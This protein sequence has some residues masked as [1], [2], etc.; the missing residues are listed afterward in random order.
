M[1]NQRVHE[2]SVQTG[3]N[4]LP[5]AQLGKVHNLIT[6]VESGKQKIHYL[7]GKWVDDGA[8]EIPLDQVPMHLRE[9]VAKIPFDPIR[10]GTPD[11]LINCEFCEFTGPGRDYAKHL[12]EK[13]VPKSAAK[14]QAAPAVVEAVSAP[15][16]RLKPEDLPPGNY[17]T[18]EEGFVI[19]NQDGTP[20]KKAGRPPKE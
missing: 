4:G 2:Y 6:F 7:D 19:I 8:N 17:A 9:A 11:V 3:P 12:V 10:E 13:H 16:V 1:E 18:D 20:R 5:I 15:E 14:P